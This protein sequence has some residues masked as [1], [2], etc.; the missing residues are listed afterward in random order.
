MAPL[1]SSGR[2]YTVAVAVVV[3][4]LPLG[5]LHNA[6]ASSSNSYVRSRLLTYDASDNSC[7]HR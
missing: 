3:V 4:T 2:Q 5:L 1:T 7:I 6:D